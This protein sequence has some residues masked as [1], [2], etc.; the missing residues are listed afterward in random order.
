[1]SRGADTEPKWPRYFDK[2]MEL[3]FILSVVFTIIFS[4]LII[5]IFMFANDDYFEADDSSR[6]EW[7]KEYHPDLTYSDCIDV[8]GW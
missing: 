3:S 2:L 8:A 1:M 4:V 7:C 5:D 6:E